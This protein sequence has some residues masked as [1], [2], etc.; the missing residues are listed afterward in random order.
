M[1]LVWDIHEWTD[2]ADRLGQYNKFEN[3]MKES[4]REIARILH[5][6][7]VATTPVETGML[8]SGWLNGDNLA[9]RVTR[10]SGGF[11][12]EL[13]NDVEYA[14]WVNY[15][16]RVR[17]QPNGPYLRVKRRV[18]VPTAHQ[19]QANT[20]D[21]FVYGHFFVER[22]ILMVGDLKTKQIV[23]NELHKWFDW[24]VNGGV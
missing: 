3:A 16:H 8:K 21:W 4:A 11:Q 14:R 6:M 15:G 18:K 22:S 2:F 24:C 1:N 7:L 17:N 19:W 9:F 10:V 5:R 12:V 13:S 23:Y 20:S